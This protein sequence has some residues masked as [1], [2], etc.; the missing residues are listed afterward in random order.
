MPRITD[1]CS[2]IYVLGC[3]LSLVR[4]CDSDFGITPVGDITI[5]ITWLAFCFHVAHISFASFWYL[6]L[7]LLL[8]LLFYYYCHLTTDS[9]RC[10]YYRDYFCYLMLPQCKYFI[11]QV[12][13]LIIIIVLLQRSGAT[14]YL[15]FEDSI[16]STSCVMC[17]VF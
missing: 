15:S 4:L 17:F 12:L 1:F 8:L 9:R 7:L 11:R 6:L 13:V 16:I 2:G 5:G 3:K 10:Y 14:S